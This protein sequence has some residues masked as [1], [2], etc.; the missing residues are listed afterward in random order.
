[1][2]TVSLS[3]VFFLCL[4]FSLSLF[5]FV[6]IGSLS[7]FFSVSVSVALTDR[8]TGTHTYTHSLFCACCLGNLWVCPPCCRDGVVSGSRCLRLTL[9]GS[10]RCWRQ[11]GVIRELEISS[12]QDEAGGGIRGSGRETNPG[13]SDSREGGGKLGFGGD[14]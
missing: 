14:S 13:G 8:Q 5:L 6:S 3:F 2:H 12:I 10:R 11:G 7:L 4:F 1:M 9:S